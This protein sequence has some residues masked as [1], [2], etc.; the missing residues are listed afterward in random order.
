MHGVKDKINPLQHFIFTDLICCSRLSLWVGY[1]FKIYTCSI[2]YQ[3][4]NLAQLK[5]QI[6]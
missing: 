4:L 2:F 6:G 5:K 3:S 1:L